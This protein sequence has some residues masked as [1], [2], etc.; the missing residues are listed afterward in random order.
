MIASFMPCGLLIKITQNSFPLNAVKI[1]Y[2][3]IFLAPP[4]DD[5]DF[6]ASYKRKFPSHAII[7]IKKHLA[8]ALDAVMWMLEG[9]WT[10]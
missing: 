9:T 1:K 4:G 8:V 3:T 10:W 2:P 7:I 6:G 5:G